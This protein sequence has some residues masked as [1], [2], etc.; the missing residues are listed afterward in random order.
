MFDRQ[1]IYLLAC[2]LMFSVVHLRAATPE[3]INYQGRIVDS[4]ALFTGA[5]S[6]VFRVYASPDNGV[7]IFEETQTVSVVDGLYSVRVGAESLSGQ[8]FSVL[9]NNQIYLEVTVGATTLQPRERIVSVPYSLRS[10]G[11]DQ[12]SIISSM[13]AD[14]AIEEEHL[15]NG[16]VTS[17]KMAL[18]GD[19]D[20][21]PWIIRGGDV[22]SGD[23][24]ITNESAF[25]VF[26]DAGDEL[27][28]VDGD[29]AEIR[30]KVHVA[31]HKRSGNTIEYSAEDSDSARAAVLL[32][33]WGDLQDGDSLYIYS[34]THT[35]IPGWS[36]NRS[37]GSQ[38]PDLYLSNMTDISILGMGQGVV[39]STTT[40][41]S[42]I[43]IEDCTNIRIE[44]IEFRSNRP[45]A[46]KNGELL[47]GCV[48]LV[49]HIQD[50][51]V[52]ECRFI[53]YGNHGVTDF[54]GPISNGE[55]RASNVVVEACYFS[56]GGDKNLGDLDSGPPDGAAFA[57]I[58][59]NTI[60]R[61]SIV[62][63]CVRGYEIEGGKS[64]IVSG[65][66]CENNLF[67]DVDDMAIMLFH[68]ADPGTYQDIRIA[69]NVTIGGK[70]GIR[71]GGGRRIQVT[72]NAIY[73]PLQRGITLTADDDLKDAT[74]SGNYVFRAGNYG[75]SIEERNA[76]D[77]LQRVHVVGNTVAQ[78]AWDGISV[79]G[80]DV[81]VQGNGCY[82]NA[83]TMVGA[84]ISLE[85][86]ALGSLNVVVSGNICVDT[87][88]TQDYG[89][90]VQTGVTGAKILANIVFGNEIDS[91]SDFGNSTSVVSFDGSGQLGVG[92]STPTSQLEVVGD[93]RISGRIEVE[94]SL[95]GRVDVHTVAAPIAQNL[96]DDDCMQDSWYFAASSTNLLPD[97]SVGLSVSFHALSN[98][99]TVA[100]KPETGDHFLTDGIL[101]TNLTNGG[102]AGDSATLTAVDDS[103]WVV[104]TCGNWSE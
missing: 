102:V 48:E 78:A 80:S 40:S 57:V 100:L 8:L 26:S 93:A 84:G 11:V 94:G 23:L 62:E 52:R 6:L 7:P 54:T 70:Q 14:G 99:V 47:Y 53:N 1:C 16:S 38:T 74:V 29:H 33:A 42:H 75:I 95:S 2:A 55:S 21:F 77:P 58:G 24:V 103:T 44:N 66:I 72:G 65:L 79:S 90:E 91:L 64:G 60:F 89:I 88:N 19:P 49:N 50:I 5:T 104:K 41:G 96:L 101:T 10:A 61:N 13:I 27:F 45:D 71:I 51:F 81:V 15:E 31:I 68:T 67:R 46:G 9:T 56:N 73:R 4:G 97:A 76:A 22:M 83:R 82:D 20:D 59:R 25:M 34:G 36:P 98:G 12:G 63:N 28:A 86:G 17:D 43:V 85:P 69:G 32:D 39:M 3:L 30:K 18:G 87:M 37:P 92:T 35:I